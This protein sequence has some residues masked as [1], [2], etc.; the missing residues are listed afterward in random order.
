[1]STWRQTTLLARI[2]NDIRRVVYG[3][4]NSNDSYGAKHMFTKRAVDWKAIGNTLLTPE[5]LGAIIG[6]AGAPLATYLVRRKK[7]MPTG[8]RLA[9][10]LAAGVL[11]AG[12]GAGIGYGG[13]KLG[14]KALEKGKELWDRI[15]GP[16][17]AEEEGAAPTEEGAAPAQPAEISEEESRSLLASLLDALKTPEAIGAVVGGT[18]AP[19]AT[20]LARR[21]KKMP[22]GQRLA[23]LLAASALGAGAG[24]GIG[25]GG[26]KLGPKAVEGAKSLAG[27][28]KERGQ[29]VLGWLKGSPKDEESEEEGE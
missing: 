29:Q 5:V 11:G 13:K 28:A 20:Y 16:A 14:P 4:I 24:A 21:K 18:A 25:Y 10:L 17:A 8:Q 26:K 9:E 6:G 27:K 15:R 3:P 23:E 1:M 22:T 2:V 7:K 19:A 12:A